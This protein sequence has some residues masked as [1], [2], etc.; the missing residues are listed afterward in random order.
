MSGGE[1]SA[2]PRRKTAF[3]CL[4]V[5]LSAAPLAEAQLP[6]PDPD[7]AEPDFTVISVATTAQVPRHKFAFKLSHRFSRPLD[8]FSDDFDVGEL[9]E[10][11]FGLDSAAKIGLELRFGLLE[12]TQVGLHRTNDRT[13]QFFGQHSLFEQG[14]RSP[15]AVDAVVTVEGLNNFRQ[16]YST[17]VGAV[18]SRRMARRVAV[19]IE[20][21]WVAN[22]N[23]LIDELGNE[24]HTLQ[25]GLGSRLRWTPSVYLVGEFVPRVAGYSPGQHYG[26]FGIEKRAGGHV[27]QLNVSNGLGTTVGQLARGSTGRNKWYIGFNLSRKFF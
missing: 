12:G 5:F 15:V 20:P 23:P 21:M 19:Y 16:D 27:F 1:G 26:S 25:I 3:L 24:N 10:N 8:G 18:I 9:V 17:G 2:S 4:G 13:I 22:T 11:L 7:P 6:G 14:E